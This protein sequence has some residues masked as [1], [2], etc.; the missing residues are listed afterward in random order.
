[1]PFAEPVTGLTDENAVVAP[2]PT[3]FA[4]GDLVALGP[5]RL[6][7]GDATSADDVDRV[8]AG[9]P[10]ALMTT[11]PPY[12]VAYEPRWRHEAYPAQRTAIGAVANDDRVDWT[13][14]WRLFPALL[15]ESSLAR[16]M[17]TGRILTCRCDTTLVG[18]GRSSD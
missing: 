8:L 17:P 11:D 14:A 16:T 9:V 18:R 4:R 13:A 1:M 7:C 5:H 6:L 15:H 10:P 3:A 12:G 2:G